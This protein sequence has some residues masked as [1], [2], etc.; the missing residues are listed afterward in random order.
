[1]QPAPQRSLRPTPLAA[2]GTI[3]D[4]PRRPP[5]LAMI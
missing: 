2:D 1:V 3:P 4:G 5:R